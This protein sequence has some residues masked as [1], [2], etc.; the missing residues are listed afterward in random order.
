MIA[1]SSYPWPRHSN[2]Q[3]RVS[4]I[5]CFGLLNG[6]PDD[7]GHFPNFRPRPGGCEPGHSQA[8][9]HSPYNFRRIMILIQIFL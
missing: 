9:F 8:F 3:C 1:T 6:S 5:T 4:Q 7:L 2:A